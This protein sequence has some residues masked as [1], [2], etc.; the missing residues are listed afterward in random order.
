MT[1]YLLT[2]IDK[3]WVRD[4]FNSCA[5]FI[6]SDFEKAWEE[7]TFYGIPQQGFIRIQFSYNKEDNVICELAVHPAC[8]RKGI[9][10]KLLNYALSPCLVATH[11]DNIAANKLYCQNGFI[12]IGEVI[13]RKGVLL[14]L[15]RR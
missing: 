5:E 3:E 13:D 8:R 14:N 6:E 11:R 2:E 7:G 15:Y 10:K 1:V 12:S 4:L 9:A